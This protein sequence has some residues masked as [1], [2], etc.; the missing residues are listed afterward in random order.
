MLLDLVDPGPLLEGEELLGHRLLLLWG[1]GRLHKGV[2]RHEGKWKHRVG[3][4]TEAFNEDALRTAGNLKKS[5]LVKNRKGKVVSANQQKAARA[6]FHY[7]S[8][9]TDATKE[10]REHLKLSGFAPLQE[11]AVLFFII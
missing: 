6:N 9:W 3:S 11:W 2:V 1:L 8:E 10:A 7:I 5:D 4:K